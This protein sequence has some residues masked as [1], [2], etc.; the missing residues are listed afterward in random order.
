MR[1]ALTAALWVNGQQGEAESNWVATI[2]LDSRYKNLD[3]VAHTRRWA[4]ALVD[5]LEKFLTL[6]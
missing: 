1:A 4:P 3:W 5:A 2:G 6:S